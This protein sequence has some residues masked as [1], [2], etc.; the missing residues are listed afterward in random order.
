MQGNCNW[1]GCIGRALL[2]LFFVAMGVLNIMG[3]QANLAMLTAHA[4]P[5]PNIILGAVIAIEIIFGLLIVF[6]KCQCIAAWILILFMIVTTAAML[7]FLHQA[8]PIKMETLMPFLSSVAV[9]GGLLLVASCKKKC[10]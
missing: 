10:E 9:I 4:L 2:G 3:W 5:V 8:G 7:Y 1:A 6:G